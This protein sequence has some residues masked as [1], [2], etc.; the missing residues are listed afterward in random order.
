MSVNTVPIRQH[1]ELLFRQFLLTCSNPENA[2]NRLTIRELPLYSIR[3][4]ILTYKNRIRQHYF[5]SGI[6]SRSARHYGGLF[7]FL[8]FS[9]KSF[10]LGTSRVLGIRSS[11]IYSNDR[12]LPME[13]RTGGAIVFAANKLP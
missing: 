7:T 2:L 9:L 6:L 3:K 13:I 10:Q 12:K 4:D 8:L 5:P 11:F 1:N